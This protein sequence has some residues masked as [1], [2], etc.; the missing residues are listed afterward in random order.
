MVSDGGDIARRQIPALGDHFA[1]LRMRELE[2]SALGVEAA[3][4]GSPPE[5]EYAPV[6][7]FS[8][9]GEDQFA[10]VVQEAGHECLVGQTGQPRRQE[11][12]LSL[13]HN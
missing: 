5:L 9:D 12:P 6:G 3:H 4:G 1:N 2:E 10:D 8:L 11:T 13:I 7:G